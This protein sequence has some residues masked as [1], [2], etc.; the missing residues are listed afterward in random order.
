MCFPTFPTS[1]SCPALLGPR[2]LTPSYLLR[3]SPL[4]PSRTLRDACCLCPDNPGWA[5]P[6]KILNLITSAES[7][8]LVGKYIWGL[9]CGH[10][11]GGGGVSLPTAP[12]PGPHIDLLRWVTVHSSFPAQLFVD[13]IVLPSFSSLPLLPSLSEVLNHDCVVLICVLLIPSTVLGTLWTLHKYLLH[14]RVAD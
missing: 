13:T 12:T 1:R 2:P 8:L 7:L 6:H 4:S 9:G 10:L 11:G 5:L 14:K 3:L